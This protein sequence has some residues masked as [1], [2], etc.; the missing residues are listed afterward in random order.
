MINTLKIFNELKQTMDPT[1][2][3]K[4]VDVIGAVYEELRNSVTKV[5]FNELKEVVKELAEAQKRTEIRLEQLTE[6]VD[7]LTE[8]VDELTVNVSRLERKVEDLVGAMKRMNE[9]I[10]DMR[11]EMGACPMQL[12]MDLKITH[13]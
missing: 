7:K 6:R 1:A 3:E 4:I 9:T 5:E 10:Q 12:V 2:A 13:I 8:R 11:Q